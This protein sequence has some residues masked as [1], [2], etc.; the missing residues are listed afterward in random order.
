MHEND[1]MQTRR[2]RGEGQQVQEGNETRKRWL[3]WME[4]I[5][6][7]VLENLAA[8]QLNSTLPDFHPDR[9]PYAMLEALGRTVEGIAPF[10]ELDGLAGEEAA[11]QDK[12]RELVRKGLRQ[13]VDPAS[14]DAMNFS[15][16]Y[17]QSLVD[18]AFLA[19]G[20][21]RAPIELGEKLDAETRQRLMAA[22]RSTRS[23]TPF[24]SNWILFSA[25]IEAALQVLGA[26]D[27]DLTRVDYAVQMFRRWYVGD[28]TYG[29]GDRFHWDFYNSFVIQPMLVDVLRV[30]EK[31]G[32]DYG[33]YLQEAVS[34]ASR[35]SRVQEQM[36]S[37]DGS[38]CVFGRST[39]YR[40]G[41][42]QL[43]SQA[44]L[45]HFLPDDLPAGQVRSCLTAAICR[46][47]EAP[48]TFDDKGF[49]QPGVCGF[50]PSLAEEYISTGSLYLCTS[51]FLPLG[52]PETDP[53]WSEPETDW[54]GKKIWSGQDTMRDHAVD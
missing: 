32:R 53:F 45:Q 50:Q 14:K 8:G 23:L 4:K 39:V 2:N 7:P 38:W 17:G 40:F 52:L 54:T 49:L 48:G 29:D 24:V 22:L 47:L 30:F 19:H 26:E 42:F 13:A 33:A 43:L 11:Y 25:M 34:H 12:M 28:G 5:V 20:I 16:G 9:R 1:T 46:S 36:I 41:C 27:A 3:Q 6:S 51:V 44:A 31:Q 15:E 21:V 35:Y 37:Y 10:L 18:A